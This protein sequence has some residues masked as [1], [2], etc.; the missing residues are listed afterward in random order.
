M[1]QPNESI[2]DFYN[3]LRLDLLSTLRRLHFRHYKRDYPG[4]ASEFG[5]LLQPGDHQAVLLLLEYLAN[6]R[7]PGRPRLTGPAVLRKWQQDKDEF[8]KERKA[9]EHR[10]G[11]RRGGRKAAIEVL[12]ARWRI[13]PEAA[14]KR[15]AGS[16]LNRWVRLTRD[17]K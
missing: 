17:S 6:S 14:K 15:I 11:K 3:Q 16:R 9:F 12:A 10:T 8:D 2:D 7:P 5:C 4:A 13:T 1:A